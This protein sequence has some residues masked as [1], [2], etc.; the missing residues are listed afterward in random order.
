MRYVAI[1]HRWWMK[2]LD[3][4]IK[5]LKSDN[6]MDAE[7]EAGYWNDRNNKQFSH[8]STVVIEIADNEQMINGLKLTL[9][10]RLRGRL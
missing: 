9:R 10:E 8:A 7:I 4:G 6:L 3:W 1:Q 5:E 2:H